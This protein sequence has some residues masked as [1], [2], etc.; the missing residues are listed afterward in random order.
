MIE[1]LTAAEATERLRAE[2]L[3]ISP[4]TVRHG[5]QQGRISVWRLR[6]GGREGQVVLCLRPK[7]APTRV[8]DGQGREGGQAMRQGIGFLLL[9]LLAGFADGLMAWSMAGFVVVGLS[10]CGVAAAMVLK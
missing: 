8:R 10:V 4:E 2:G 5:I 7:I 6:H 3:K 9:L 1:A